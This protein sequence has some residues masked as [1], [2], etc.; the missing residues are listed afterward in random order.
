MSEIK[1]PSSAHLWVVC[2]MK[3]KTKSGRSAVITDSLWGSVITDCAPTKAQSLILWPDS[4]LCFHL[5][6]AK[7]RS[8][9][10]RPLT[11]SL[12]LQPPGE[13]VP[14]Y[15]KTVGT[16]SSETVSLKSGEWWWFTEMFGSNESIHLICILLFS[17]HPENNTLEQPVNIQVTYSDN[18]TN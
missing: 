2:N 12:W 7:D 6:A 1:R 15:N 16:F 13:F 4:F 5:S 14:F 9:S 11:H 10:L 8:A 3:I 17:G 18:K